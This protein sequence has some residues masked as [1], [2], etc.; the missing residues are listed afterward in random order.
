MPASYPDLK[1]KTVLVT[2][3]AS[4]IGAA[5]VEAFAAQ[6]ARVG[7]LDIDERQGPRRSPPA[8]AA[9]RRAS[10]PST[11]ATSP[12]SRPAVERGARRARADHR[13]R[14]QRRPRRAATPRSRSRPSISTSA[15]RSTSSTSSS[16]P[17]RCIPDM[18]AAGGGAIIC[19]SSIVPMARHGRDAGL[20]RLQVR[21]DRPRPLARPRLRRPTT[22][23]ST[24]S[25][26]AGS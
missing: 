2:G 10:R 7:F 5:L 9:A 16:P 13:A 25:P 22:S 20:R 21:G 18:Q 17:R 11:C 26:P 4:G 14:Q 12:R 19:F 6:G 15:S 1:D 8:S 3:G 24:S 23:A